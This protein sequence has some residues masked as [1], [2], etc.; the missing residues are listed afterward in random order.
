MTTAAR[1]CEGKLSGAAWTSNDNTYSTGSKTGRNGRQQ[2]NGNGEGWRRRE[3][4]WRR[5]TWKSCQG[6]ASVRQNKE[7]KEGKVHKKWVRRKIY[8][9]WNGAIRSKPIYGATIVDEVMH[10]GSNSGQK[11][12]GTLPSGGFQC[13]TEADIVQATIR[14]KIGTRH[15]VRTQGTGCLDGLP[16]RQSSTWSSDRHG[17]TWSSSSELKFRVKLLQRFSLVS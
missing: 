13:T 5:G 12:I 3:P 10:W 15:G 14:S 4:P 16:Q 9:L 11:W 1:R 8:L 17:V 2:W 6:E 7:E